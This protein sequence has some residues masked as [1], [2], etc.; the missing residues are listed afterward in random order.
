MVSHAWLAR[1]WSGI[2]VANGIVAV[3]ATF[4]FLAW[5]SVKPTWLTSLLLA[6]AFAHNDLNRVTVAPND[7]QREIEIFCLIGD[8]TGIA[9]ASYQLL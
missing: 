3:I 5:V 2:S 1:L 7:A 9:V 8:L 4:R 6:V